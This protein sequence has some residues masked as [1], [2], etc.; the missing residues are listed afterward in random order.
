MQPVARQV[1][2]IKRERPACGP[3]DV[4]ALWNRL[5]NCLKRQAPTLAG[6]LAPGAKAKAIKTFEK[7]I[8]Q[9]LPDDL[10]QSLLIHHGQR[11]GPDGQV[12]PV[13]ASIRLMSLQ[14][15]FDQRNAWR[16][17]DEDDDLQD[18]ENFTSTPR[19]AI[20]LR[21]SSEE[22][23]AL[24]VPYS[25]NYLGVDLKP[26]PKGFLGQVINFGRDEDDKFVLAWSWAWFLHD[27]VMEL[28]QGNFREIDDGRSGLVLVNPAWDGDNFF[29]NGI[30]DWSKAK[31]GGRRPF[32]PHVDLSGLRTTTVLKL[33]QSL[34][35]GAAFDDLPILGDALEE[36]GCTDAEVLRHCREPGEH[37][38]SCWLIDLLLEQD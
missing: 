25:S 20:Q 17:L 14:E 33:A 13:I 16:N 30:R 4:P 11:P 6:N 3:V 12:R 18:P 35:K 21:Y 5:E 34:K 37:G 38:T 27:L 36:A 1:R 24:A 9:A 19:K 2:I 22:W 8:G 32:N 7:A 29:N 31:N 26:G 10:R 28:A 23:I 15:S